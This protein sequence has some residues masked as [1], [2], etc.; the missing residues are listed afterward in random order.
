MKIISLS[1][2]C[3]WYQT[4]YNEFIN[5]MQSSYD[6]YREFGSR[7]NK[8]V[9]I[10]H[11][12][13]HQNLKRILNPAIYDIFEEKNIPAL[14]ASGKK[15]VDIVVYNKNTNKYV[16]VICVKFICSN[17]KQNKNNYLE[18]LIGECRTIKL[19]QP[20]IK[21]VPF[22]IFISKCPYFKKNKTL[23]KFEIITYEKDLH[24]YD[25]HCCN[26]VYDYII[27]YLIDIDYENKKVIGFNESSNYII[28]S[29]LLQ[30]V[31]F[32]NC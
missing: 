15:K 9:N 17:Y 24:I 30:H 21:I 18:S 14:N 11:N 7:S 4:E 20:H 32:F 25:K 8:K 16:L 1:N 31:D 23:K 5:M 19:S 2:P 12:W 3:S 29:N 22:N 13:I 10:I 26:E 28:F 6:V 27:T